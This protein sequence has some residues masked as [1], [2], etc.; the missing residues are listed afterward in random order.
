MK[1]R[2]ILLVATASTMLMLLSVAAS[3]QFR[4]GFRAGLGMSFVKAS[5]KSNTSSK[6]VSFQTTPSVSF[7]AG[8]AMIYQI[9]ISVGQFEIEAD[10]LFVRS[11]SSQTLK[12][13]DAQVYKQSMAHYYVRVPIRANLQ[14]SLGHMG[15]YLGAG[16][17]LGYMVSASAEKNLL[18]GT[19]KWKDKDY[20]KNAKKVDFGVTFHA[21]VQLPFPLR[22]G[23]YV[24]L[25]FL[26]TTVNEIKEEGVQFQTKNSFDAGITLAYI[27]GAEL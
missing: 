24:N 12:I 25:G 4:A 7:Q 6:A 27:F 15:I 20:Y 23:A 14:F 8:L 3:A 22:I 5:E 16:P 13:A 11:A 17:Y 18:S 10:A 21:G 9:P 19:V 2:K 1:C 26:P